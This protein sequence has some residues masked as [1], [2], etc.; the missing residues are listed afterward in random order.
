M[1]TFE[2]LP[3]VVHLWVRTRA[4]VMM[5]MVRVV[6]VLVRWSW[7]SWEGTT[8]PFARWRSESTVV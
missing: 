2:D 4:S 3:I 7:S 5:V 1:C 8:G 6:V